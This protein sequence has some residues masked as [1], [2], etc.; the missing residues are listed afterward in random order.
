MKLDMDMNA[1]ISTTY[2][3]DNRHIMISYDYS[4]IEIC[5]KIY[6][7][8]VVSTCGLYI[9]INEMYFSSGTKLPSMDGF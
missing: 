3:Q 6:Q 7:H 2:N 8:L 5:R 9:R 1:T 4:S